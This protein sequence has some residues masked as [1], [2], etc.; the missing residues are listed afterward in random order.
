MGAEEGMAPVG[1]LPPTRGPLPDDVLPS[2]IRF[3][4]LLTPEIFQDQVDRD[5][6]PVFPRTNE[7]RHRA[8]AEP[9]RSG[10]PP[11]F[12][13]PTTPAQTKFDFNKTRSRPIGPLEAAP[14]TINPAEIQS[15]PKALDPAIA[16]PVRRN[17]LRST[18]RV[19]AT[20][21]FMLA[22]AAS[23]GGITV[24]SVGIVSMPPVAL[25]LIPPAEEITST[26][27]A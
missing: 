7:T 3:A 4:E 18:V 5:G 26:P 20:L 1:T 21:A 10:P 22:G 17:R 23:M 6:E 8:K 12:V 16:A 24:R 2:L 19:A 14:V 11:A 9:V 15:V 27:I 13:A 25:A